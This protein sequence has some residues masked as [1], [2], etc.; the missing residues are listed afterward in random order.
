MVVE[1]LSFVENIL[2]MVVLI[3]FDIVKLVFFLDDVVLDDDVFLVIVIFRLVLFGL[4]CLSLVKNI[5]CGIV[6]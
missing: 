2:S 4:L 6:R 5:N 3:L 1:R